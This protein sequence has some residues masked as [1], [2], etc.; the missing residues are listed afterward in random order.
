MDIESISGRSRI[1]RGWVS[2]LSGDAGHGFCVVLMPK[3]RCGRAFWLCASGQ[4]SN[5]M[6]RAA[7]GILL[8]LSGATRDRSRHLNL[9]THN[10]QPSKGGWLGRWL[11][12]GE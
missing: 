10:I 5:A 9:R 1:L 6:D 8:K 2:D 7:Q 4:Y 12:K 3:N 11:R